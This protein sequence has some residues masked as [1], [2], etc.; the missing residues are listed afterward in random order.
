VEHPHD[1]NR[2]SLI[3]VVN[4]DIFRP[5]KN[6]SRNAG[7]RDLKR[8]LF[9]T[10]FREESMTPNEVETLV[11]KK[12]RKDTK[13]QHLKEQQGEQL[14][15]LSYSID[16][17]KTLTIWHTE[18]PIAMQHLGIGGALV[19][20]AFALADTGGASLRLVCPFSKDYL[21]R[22]PELKAESSKIGAAIF[23]KDSLM[24]MS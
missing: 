10:K 11:R 1:A 12:T 15:F 18:V 4:Q 22:H 17:R 16:E 14:A 8:D 7:N 2:E 13:V 21:A 5:M 3:S 20:K 19:K 23:E 6:G 9:L 24:S